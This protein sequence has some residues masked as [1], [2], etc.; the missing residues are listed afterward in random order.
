MNAA[1]NKLFILCTIGMAEQGN[2]Q[3]ANHMTVEETTP[4]QTENEITNNNST[5]SNSSHTQV[6]IINIYSS[7]Y[8]L[9]SSAK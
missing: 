8:A 1:I 3:L 6:S 2:N 5:I 9:E 4:T 7:L